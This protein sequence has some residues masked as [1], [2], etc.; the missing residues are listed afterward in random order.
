VVQHLPSK[1]KVLSSKPSTSKK[2]LKQKNPENNKVNQNNPSFL[3]RYHIG[4]ITNKEVESTI[5][6]PLKLKALGPN[7][8]VNPMKY[9]KKN[10]T[11]SLQPL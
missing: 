4:I 11:N 7:G 9:L 6:N 2:K 10:Y 3:K 5:N 8:L 1:H